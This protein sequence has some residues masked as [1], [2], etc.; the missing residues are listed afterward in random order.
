MRRQWTIYRRVYC[1]PFRCSAGSQGMGTITSVNKLPGLSFTIPQSFSCFLLISGTRCKEISAGGMWGR[2][3]E[4][5]N[6]ND[7]DNDIDS[8]NRWDFRQWQWTRLLTMAVNKL[9]FFLFKAA[10]GRK[11]LVCIENS[12]IIIIIIRLY[13]HFQDH[14]KA[15]GT[16][17][18]IIMINSNKYLSWTLVGRT[19]ECKNRQIWQPARI[20]L[21]CQCQCGCMFSWKNKLTCSGMKFFKAANI[22]QGDHCNIGASTSL[23]HWGPKD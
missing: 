17:Q 5:N 15:R 1:G 23:R 8:D 20:R 3:E 10:R 14:K 13:S 22:F 21:I 12:C 4:E 11:E 18:K 16:S 6:E 7:N 2:M 9:G 19:N